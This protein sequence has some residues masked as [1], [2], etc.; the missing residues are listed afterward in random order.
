M[1]MDDDDLVSETVNSSSCD[2]HMWA[3]CMIT[4]HTR[5]VEYAAHKAVFYNCFDIS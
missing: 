5:A 3:S 4:I 2:G 1:L